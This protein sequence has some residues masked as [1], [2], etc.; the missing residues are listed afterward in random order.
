MKHLQFSLRTLFVVVTIAGTT[1]G[2]AGIKVRD[3]IRRQEKR[4]ALKQIG[5]HTFCHP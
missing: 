1:L 3:E 5:L 2:L 4:E